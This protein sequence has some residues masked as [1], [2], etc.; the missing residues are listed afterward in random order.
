MRLHRDAAGRRKYGCGN[1]YARDFLTLVDHKI[2]AF[3][4]A[5]RPIENQ[6]RKPNSL[7][8][9]IPD[10]HKFPHNPLSKVPIA[11][12]FWWKVKRTSIEERQ[13]MQSGNDLI[14]VNHHDLALVVINGF[15]ADEI[16]EADGELL[17]W[18]LFFDLPDK[19]VKSF[20]AEAHYFEE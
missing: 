17:V 8:L 14:T 2:F 6:N 4:V 3:Q 10:A 7:L 19:L 20:R 1:I 15:L 16:G 18:N 12:R 13:I 11:L 5:D 9:V